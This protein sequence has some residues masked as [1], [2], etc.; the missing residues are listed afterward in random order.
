MSRSWP[1]TRLGDV[2]R[3]KH[4]F[5]FKG[6]EMASSEVDGPI[7]VGIGNFDY[8]GG[9]RFESTAVKRYL[10]DYA[11]EFRLKAGDVLLAM[12]CQTP[13]GEILGIPGTVPDDHNIYLHNQRL[14]KIEITDESRID[15][16]FVFQLARGSAFNRYLFATAS[17]SKILHTSPSRIEGFEC[18]LPPLEEQRG[19][20]ATLGALDDKIDSNT[21]MIDVCSQLISAQVG[22]AILRES[23]VVPVSDLAKFV[24]GGAYTKGATGSGRMVVR[25]KELNSG[26]GASTVFNDIDVP[27]EKTAQP[28]DILMSWSGSLGVY[29]W[30]RD[31]AIINQHIFKVLPVGCPYWLVFDRLQS[32]IGEFQSIA[33]DKAT[34]MGH[35]QRRHLETT[36]VRLPTPPLIDTLNIVLH[37]L[38][39]RIKVAE[40][41]NQKLESLRDA[42][43]PELLS[44]RIRVPEAAEAV[45]SV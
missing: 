40:T 18:P 16:E 38:W 44:G 19:I 29:R 31:E 17:G 6:A 13:G 15:S 42:L 5:A 3:V 41:E 45:A 7:V 37:P 12:T 1:R 34:T 24:N 33:R 8:A 2:L 10:A 21:R 23:D 27:A 32:V 22:R 26:P 39:E 20:A 43:L 11:D 35:I 28:G 9:F 4:G 36:A 25:I 14:G 30:F